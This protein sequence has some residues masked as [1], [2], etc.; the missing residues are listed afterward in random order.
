M[1]ESIKPLNSVFDDLL[2]AVV[3]FGVLLQISFIKN[4]A[5]NGKIDTV[6]QARFLGERDPVL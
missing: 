1:Y 4:E 2:H 6:L 3:G 5:N